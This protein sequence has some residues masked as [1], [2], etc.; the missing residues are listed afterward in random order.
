M[1]NQFS[2]LEKSFILNT[3][4]ITECH[5]RGVF[6]VHR[7]STIE[8]QYK[9]D[10]HRRRK[11]V[12]RKAYDGIIE[13]LGEIYS[14]HKGFNSETSL[15]QINEIRDNFDIKLMIVGHF[16]AGK[17]TLLNMLIGKPGFLKEAQEPQTAIATELIYDENESA[18]AFDEDGNKELI[19]EQKEYSPKDYNHL[20]YR[21][22]S[23]NLKKISDFTI[24]D[25][26]GFDAGIEIHA[27]ALANY[28]GVGSAYLVVIDQEKGG[29]DKTTLEFIQ[30]IS[31]YS[32]QIAVIIN[33]CDK[34]T[35]NVAES[36]AES[37]RFTLETYGYNYGVYTL[38]R[39]DVDIAEKLIS[40][41]STFNA[42]AA[43]DKVMLKHLKSELIS[44]EKSLSIVQKKIF[45]DTFDL[46]VDLE[47]YSRVVKYLSETFKKKKDESKENLE[48]R[49]QEVT[50]RIRAALIERAD[51]VVDALL[52]G[53]NVAAE[54]IVLE[55]IRPIMVST[56]KEISI[57]EID[58]VTKELNFT[59]LLKEEDNIDLTEVTVN[60]A[61][62]LK[63]LIEEKLM[64]AKNPKDSENGV[65]KKN[66]YRMVTG[67]AAIATDLIAPWLEI[68]IIL[69]PDI[70]NFLKGLFGESNEALAKRRFINNVIP[71]IINKMY[72][73]I[74]QNIET[75]TNM[76]LDE[77][78]KL[79]AEKID[80]IKKNMAEAQ[81][82]RQ[83]KIQDFEEYKATI[84]DDISQVKKL[85][86]ELR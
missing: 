74:M 48:N 45:L 11:M 56:M 3:F 25:T 73:Q 81:N 27:K 52:S 1:L 86:K 78:E 24:V 40:I 70:V 38:S 4:L 5:L 61:N 16:S 77:Y 57:R 67:I 72:P 59:G 20:E 12:N 53:N 43:F 64:K 65:K 42:Q 7:E 13:K 15:E 75:T 26:P 63:L 37:A 10:F 30:E 33:K 83:Q 79:T 39:K 60:L 68:V 6:Y 17:S 46:D 47:K 36:I 50:N 28:I 31:N 69:L 80:S 44:S 8:T 49:V 85:M 51:S 21:I 18:F 32:S 71:Q 19:E 76:V 23:E 66:I 2:Y 55:I 54:A 82:K 84:V 58:S 9:Y 62:N 14:H 41:I 34:I 35:D 22:N 29:I